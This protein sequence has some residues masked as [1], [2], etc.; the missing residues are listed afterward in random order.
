[1][2]QITERLFVG[3]IYDAAQPPT[4]IGAL[5]FVAGEYEIELPRGIETGHIPFKEFGE[6]QAPLLANAVEWVEKH[7]AENR[8]MVCCRAGMG[9]S[10]SVVMAYLCCVERMAY[11]QVL[12]LVTT[13]RP[14]AM[15]LPNLEDTIKGVQQIRQAKKSS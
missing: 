11:S 14:G 13:K 6:A 3:N 4:Q 1:M 9:R 8:V 7:V 12:K 15:P 2:H 10:V 5:L